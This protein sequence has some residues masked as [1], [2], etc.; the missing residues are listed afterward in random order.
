MNNNVLQVKIKQR[1][2][3]LASN[4]YNN[5]ECWQIAEA[6]NKAQVE[7]VRRQVHGNNLR[8]EGDESSKSLIDDLQVLLTEQS[9]SGNN[10]G[11]YFETNLIPANYMYFK[12]LSIKSQTECCPDR[13]VS[14]YLA[15]VANVS[16]LLDDPFRRPSAEWGETFCTMQG[17]RFRIYHDNKFTVASPKLT[18]YRFPQAVSFVGCVNPATGAPTIDVES[19][20]KDDIVEI[21]IDEAAAIL[22][23]DIELFNQYQRTKTNS[24]TN[25]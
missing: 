7:W 23:G 4:D 3:K 15:E 11:L 2:N 17:N 8:R 10:Q 21:I 6:F 19:E 13:S 22:A 16:S 24:Q 12:S 18:Y 9:I 1:L 5:V 14:C 25:T 20:F